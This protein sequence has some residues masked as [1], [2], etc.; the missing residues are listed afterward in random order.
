MANIWGTLIM[1]TSLIFMSLRGI[2]GR[3]DNAVFGAILILIMLF[4][5]EGL[6]KKRLAGIKT[7]RVKKAVQN[8][9]E[10]EK[11]G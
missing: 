2:F 9:N 4:A 8:N 10:E 1:G 6:L 5:P 3:Y 7:P 11:P